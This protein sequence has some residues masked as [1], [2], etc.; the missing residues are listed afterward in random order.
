MDDKTAKLLARIAKSREKLDF[1]AQHLKSHFVGLDDVI[2]RIISSIEAWYCMPELSTRPTIVC[3]WGLTG[4]GKTD[5]VRRLVKLLEMA[6]R[7]VEVQMTNKGSSQH[8]ATTMQGLLCSSNLSPEEPGVLLLDEIQRF[9]SVDGDGKEISDYQFQDLWMLL[10]DGSF[11]SSANRK[12]AIVEL[13]CEAMYSEDWQKAND[14]EEMEEDDEDG[15]PKKKTPDRRRFKQGYWAA[16]SL[17][18]AIGLTETVEA[19]M[20]W[21]NRKKLELLS[22][23]LDDKNTYEPEVYSKLLIF[24][25]GNLDEAYHMSAMTEETDID[26]DIFHKNSLSI[27]LLNIKTA[28][29]SRFKPE[30]IARFGNTQ[31]IY[32]ALSRSS[33]E[34]IIQ[35]RI[36][37]VLIG[38]KETSGVDIRVDASIYDSIYRNGVFPVQGTRPVFSTISSLFESVLPKFT[39]SC[40]KNGAT[41]LDLKYIDKHLVAIIDGQEMRVK[42]EGEID[43]IKAD[44]RNI[45]K[46]CRVAAHEAGHALAY[47]L[48]F[49]VFPTQV[50]AA[51]ASDDRNGFIGLHA[52]DSNKINMMRQIAVLMA[53]RV[54]EIIIFGED[55]VSAGASE[56]IRRATNIAASMV[57]FFGMSDQQTRIGVLAE[58]GAI[59]TNLDIDPTNEEIE[60]IVCQ[61]QNEVE[62]LLRK[63]LPALRD[64]I[65]F[66]IKNEKIEF[67]DYQCILNRHKIN[68]EFLDAKETLFSKFHEIYENF[69]NTIS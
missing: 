4:N 44:K 9:R 26:A 60:N 14:T 17:K 62:E 47:S 46:M 54:A 33:F 13:L 19:I 66:L 59:G 55:Y 68:V 25:S 40:L 24:V 42:N 23:M 65:D 8:T 39:M 6:D 30:Q 5:L 45:D 3:L 15:E 36:R 53:G 64:L 63:N 49:G 41:R 28:L 58:G 21:D 18:K 52:I 10:S 7:F 16:K 34:L 67:A 22:V 43:K 1:A 48:E 38:V 31:I 56:D 50:V 57:R 37:D 69:R 29:R 20:E 35:R 51:A 27:N 61:Q 12:Q 32:P 11:G 2:D